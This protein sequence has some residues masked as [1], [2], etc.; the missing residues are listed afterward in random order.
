MSQ[1]KSKA[2]RKREEDRGYRQRELEDRPYLGEEGSVSQGGREG[3]ELN[4][5]IG[6]RDEKK[7]SEERPAGVT[8]VRKKDQEER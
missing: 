4:R 2:E 8:R 1:E 6:S 5:D 3:G 7:R